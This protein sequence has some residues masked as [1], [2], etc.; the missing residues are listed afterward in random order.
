MRFLGSSILLLLTYIHRFAK[1][2]V[3]VVRDG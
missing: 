3:D 1:D 2:A